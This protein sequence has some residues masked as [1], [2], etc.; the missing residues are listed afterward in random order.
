[1]D[2][3]SLRIS[4]DVVPGHVTTLEEEQGRLFSCNSAFA[5]V[6][7]LIGISKRAEAQKLSVTHIIN[8]HGHGDHTNGNDKARKLTGAPLLAYKS[9]ATGPDVKVDHG[10]TLDVGSLELKFLYTPG[11]ADDHICVVCGDV[12]ITG[13]LLFVGKVG[14]TGS[15][16][17]AKAEYP[18]VPWRAVERIRIEFRPIIDYREDLAKQGTILHPASPPPFGPGLGGSHRYWAMGMTPEGDLDT[19]DVRLVERTPYP[20]PITIIELTCDGSLR[21]GP[22]ECLDSLDSLLGGA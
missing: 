1:M 18:G 20:T 13:D 10:D 21:H 7:L 9:A 4:Q 2:E 5:P 17:T 16:E 22:S 19:D 15:D 11:H 14:G 6:P 8:T 3:I 12:A